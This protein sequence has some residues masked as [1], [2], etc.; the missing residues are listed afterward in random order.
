VDLKTFLGMMKSVSYSNHQ[1]AKL[2]VSHLFSPLKYREFIPGFGD[3]GQL[4]MTFL[5][6]GAVYESLYNEVP[7]LLDGSGA[8]INPEYN[9]PAHGRIRMVLED[10]WGNTLAARGFMQPPTI[11]VPEDGVIMCSSTFE[12]TGPPVFTRAVGAP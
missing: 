7:Y 11:E 2:E 9:P 4:Q 5:Y 10:P 8:L 6:S 1:I 3:G 12:I